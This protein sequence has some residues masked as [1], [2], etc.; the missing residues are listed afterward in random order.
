M[1]GEVIWISN[2]SEICNYQVVIY[3]SR[4]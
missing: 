3:Q 4:V 2:A 1:K